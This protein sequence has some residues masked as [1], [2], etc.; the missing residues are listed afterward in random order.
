MHETDIYISIGLV[1][2]G[3]L[4][5]FVL[6]YQVDFLK[7]KFNKPENAVTDM[8]HIVHMVNSLLN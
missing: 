3:H 8:T 2:T 7:K 4:I 5:F 6:N 1:K